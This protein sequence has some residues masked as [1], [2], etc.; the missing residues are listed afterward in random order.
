MVQFF[1]ISGFFVA[2]KLYGVNAT[3]LI[4]VFVLY[5]I[6]LYCIVLCCIV[7]YCIVLYCIV[8]YCNV[9][10]CIV[11]YCIVLYCIVLYC[12]VLYFRLVSTLA[13][14][15]TN[16]LQE[17]RLFI[18]VE[19]FEPVLFNKLPHTNHNLKFCKNES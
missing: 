9:L 2:S 8:L 11:L 17:R 16:L 12:I 4:F 7:L 14:L 6:V 3:I 18:Q 10:Y 15:L 5:C 13:L 19:H 1:I